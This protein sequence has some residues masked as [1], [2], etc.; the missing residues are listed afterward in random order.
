MAA[1]AAKKHSRMNI[2]TASIDHLQFL[3]GAYLDDVVVLQGKLTYVGRTS[4]EVKVETYVE[5]KSGL[6]TLINCAY[7]T[8]VALDKNGKPAKVPDLILE[9]E[10]DRLEWAK[11]EKRRAMRILHA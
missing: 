7:I 4:M 10:E 3:K 2:T 5:D 11:G 8:E 9:T 1:L 6:R